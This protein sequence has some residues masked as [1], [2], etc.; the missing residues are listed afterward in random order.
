MQHSIKLKLSEE[1][2]VL[3]KSD[4]GNISQI[5]LE[6][7]PANSDQIGYMLQAYHPRQKVSKVNVI[8]ERINLNIPE[9]ISF[10]ISYILE[11]FNACSAIDSEDRETMHVTVKMDEESGTL[12]LI[13][14]YWPSLD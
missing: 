12:N 4:L 9:A 13:G 1:Q 6:V 11:E 8:A 2:Q 3:L 10:K 7:I 5:L 14:E